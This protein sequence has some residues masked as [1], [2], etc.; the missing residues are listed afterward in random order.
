MIIIFSVRHNGKFKMSGLKLR[1]KL[2]GDQRGLLLREQY[3]TAV[4]IRRLL[5]GITLSYRDAMH[6]FTQSSLFK[7]YESITA[8]AVFLFFRTGRPEFFFLSLEQCQKKKES[9]REFKIR[10]RNVNNGV[11]HNTRIKRKSIKEFY[12]A[13]LTRK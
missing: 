6:R 7:Y 1:N 11:M 12:E 10:D 2:L 13:Y 8:L 3:K 4:S 5:L 9:F